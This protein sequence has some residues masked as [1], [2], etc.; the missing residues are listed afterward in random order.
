M[1]GTLALAAPAA[2]TVTLSD[3][4]TVRLAAGEETAVEVKAAPLP[5]L[6]EQTAA[7]FAARREAD[8]VGTVELPALK[9]VWELNPGVF[10]SVHCKLEL[11]G[12]HTLRLRPATGCC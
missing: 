10:I 1:T 4:R 7:I 2:A 5:A 3:G 8:A 11:D 9:P 6:T 12:V